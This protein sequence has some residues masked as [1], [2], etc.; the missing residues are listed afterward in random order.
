MSTPRL[1]PQYE[2]VLR[3]V[4]SAEAPIS[5]GALERALHVSRPTINRALRGLLVL[6]FLERQGAVGPPAM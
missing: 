3:L 5:P 4:A 6:G 2:A 1:S